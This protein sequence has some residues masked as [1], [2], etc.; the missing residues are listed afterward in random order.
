MFEGIIQTL[1]RAINTAELSLFSISAL[2]LCAQAFAG[3]HVS[4]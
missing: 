3:I 4:V 1:K 2:S